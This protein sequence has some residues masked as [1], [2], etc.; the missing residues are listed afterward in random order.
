LIVVE[1]VDLDL[2]G[3]PSPH[4]AHG[5]KLRMEN[6]RSNDSARQRQAAIDEARAKPR[7]NFGGRATLETLRHQP[8]FDRRTHC[9]L[10]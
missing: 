5:A 7:D 3:A 9:G 6:P 10:R 8:F 2:A 1:M 4:H